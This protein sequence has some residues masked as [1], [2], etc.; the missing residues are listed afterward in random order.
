MGGAV[1]GPRMGA[2]EWGLLG[3]LALLWGG[4]FVFAEVALRDLPP[5]TV[6]LGRVGLAALVL[7]A[8]VLAG[9]RRLPPLGAA[10]GRS[11]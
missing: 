4:S 7:H 6:V 8:V 10:W 11:S 2:T 3:A 1:G 9:G 5:L